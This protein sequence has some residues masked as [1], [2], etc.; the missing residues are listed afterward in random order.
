MKKVSLLLGLCIMMLTTLPMSAQTYK[1][2]K[3]A[4]KAT[5]EMK[6]EQAAEEAALLHKMKMD[7]IRKAA[8]RAEAQ[9]L[10]EEQEEAMREVEVNVP[11]CGEEFFSTSTLLRASGNGQSMNQQVAK[12]MARSS[13]LQ[14][15]TSKV[16]VAVDGVY[17][18]KIDG[19][20]GNSDDYYSTPIGIGMPFRFRPGSIEPVQFNN[21]YGHSSS[22]VLSGGYNPLEVGAT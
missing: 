7:S 12:N 20:V 21:T 16:K 11:C 17:S 14:E 2:K 1:D 9:R 15:L 8:E 3:E 10:R 6:Q 5:W 13:A 18:I 4:K 19:T 22:I